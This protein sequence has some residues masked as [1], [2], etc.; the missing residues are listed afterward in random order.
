MTG[1]DT[2]YNYR[3]FT[4]HRNLAA[5]AGDLLGSFEISTKVG[6]F[7]DGHD[8]DA[9]RVRAAV[10]EIPEVLGR[11]PS[12]VLLHNPECSV[13]DFE[14]A[15][16]ALAEMCDAGYC[17]SWG[18]STWNPR[19]LAEHRWTIPQPDIV[20]VRAGLRVPAPVLDAAERLTRQVRARR[21]WGMA[22]FGGSTED[23]LWSTIDTSLFLSSSQK[24]TAVQAAVSAAFAIPA[25]EKLCV[26]TTSATHLAEIVQA[27]SLNVSTR[28]VERYRALLSRRAERSRTTS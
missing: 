21:V 3:G 1:L 9:E 19:A 5:V 12:A 11:L 25:V 16:E 22:P 6:F 17:H 13:G 18:F 20:M 2:A 10:Q 15:C 24:G 14:K 26:G 4:A 7:P 27:E 8:I 23:P 28:V